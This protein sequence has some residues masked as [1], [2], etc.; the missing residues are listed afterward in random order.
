VRRDATNEIDIKAQAPSSALRSLDFDRFSFR[1]A[2]VLLIAVLR[3][4]SLIGSLLRSQTRMLHTRH[5]HPRVTRHAE[6][7]TLTTCLLARELIAN[8]LAT[9]WRVNRTGSDRERERER[10]P[11]YRENARKTGVSSKKISPRDFTRNTRA[12]NERTSGTTFEPR[13]SRNT[14]SLNTSNTSNNHSIHRTK[15]KLLVKERFPRR[16]SKPD[17]KPEAA[18]SRLTRHPRVNDT[19]INR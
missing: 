3:L 12:E 19:R 9:N 2:A 7:M 18:R 13:A 8:L 15:P 17:S 1:H 6:R 10:D 11:S 16:D 4:P 5:V 14:S